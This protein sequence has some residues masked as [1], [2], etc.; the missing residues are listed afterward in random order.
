MGRARAMT[1]IETL[2][3]LAII[4]LISGIAI[5]GLG[6]RSSAKLKAAAAQLAGSIKIA[7]A[8]SIATSKSVRL[9]FDFSTNKTT[10]EVSPDR[11]LMKKDP[12]G[13]ANPATQLEQE[14]LEASKAIADGPQTPRAQFDVATAFGMP[15]AGRDLPSGINFWRVQ[16][17][18]DADPVSEGRAYLYFFPNGQTEAASMQLRVSNSDEAED[19]NYLTVVVSPLTGRA[20]VKRGRVEI[21]PP[22]EDSDLSERPE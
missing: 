9:V 2:V 16:T 5:L 22:I 8:H 6:V 1:L 10:M 19:S 21:T 20:E 4:A 15:K 11:H 18:H 12:A 17:Q 7:Y 13:G 14:A 3:T